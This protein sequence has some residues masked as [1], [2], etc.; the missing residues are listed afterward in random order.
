MIE[1]S[2]LILLLCFTLA[3]FVAIFFTTFGTLIILIGAFVYALTTKFSVIGIPT[4]A[5]LLVCYIVGEGIEYLGVIIG[6]KKFG[7]SNRAIVGAL[8]GGI[9]GAFLG[10][11]FLGI[12]I[13]PGTFVGIFCGAF[14]AEWTR[15]RDFKRAFKSGAG[16]VVGRIIA[17]AGKVVV[18][19]I[20]ILFMLNRILFYSPVFNG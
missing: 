9:L 17:I 5:I 1:I 15:Q 13:V 12:G 14:L 7:A 18:A 4:A 8:L 20:M 3:G 6:A 10:V 2:A 19:L 16:G 11:W